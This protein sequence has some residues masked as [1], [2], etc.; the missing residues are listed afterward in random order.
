MSHSDTS[1]LEPGDPKELTEVLYWK[2]GW[3]RRYVWEGRVFLVPP[4][5]MVGELESAIWAGYGNKNL[6]I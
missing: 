5:E 4:G 2:G 1:V 6:L 3:E